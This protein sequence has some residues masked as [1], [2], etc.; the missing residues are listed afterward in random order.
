MNLIKIVS[1]SLFLAIST[2]PLH[3][4]ETDLLFH[5]GNL[6]FAQSRSSTDTSFPGTLSA[7]GI[8]ASVSQKVDDSV[9]ATAAFTM[10]PVLRNTLAATLRYNANYF[11]IEGGP[12]FG[13]LNTAGTLLKTGLRAS[14]T[15]QLPGVVFI[16]FDSGSTIGATLVQNGDYSEEMSEIVAGFYVYNAICSL[17]LKQSA[18]S[19]KDANGIL[20]DSFRE[21]SFQTDVF[22]KNVPYNVLLKFGYQL[23]SKYFDYVVPATHTL[24]SLVLAARVTVR[25]SNLLSLVTGFEGNI[26]TFGL[27]SLSGVTVSDKLLF[28]AQAG[29]KLNLDSATSH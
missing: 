6:D 13:V 18:F 27:D 21:Y 14:L 7:W 11:A 17:H 26:Y 15:A 1:V 19:Q 28:R 5:L 16:T 20:R 24:A 9:T 8:D 23:Q 10:D 12:F 2:L 3:A 29:I 25:M 22:R 4:L